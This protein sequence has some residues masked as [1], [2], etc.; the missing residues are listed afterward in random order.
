[1]HNPVTGIAD[2]PVEGMSE[3]LVGTVHDAIWGQP[4]AAAQRRRLVLRWL[5]DFEG[6]RII[7]RMG[8]QP[9]LAMSSTIHVRRK[10][11]VIRRISRWKRRKMLMMVQNRLTQHVMTNTLH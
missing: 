9:V 10:K 1:M 6:D 11:K 8:T 5:V 2:G 4:F 7:G 3:I